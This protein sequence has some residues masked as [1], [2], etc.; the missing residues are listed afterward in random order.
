[1]NLSESLGNLIRNLKE[2]FNVSFTNASESLTELFVDGSEL[3][4]QMSVNRS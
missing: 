1:M 3:F 4:S 2:L